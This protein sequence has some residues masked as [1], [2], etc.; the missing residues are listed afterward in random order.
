MD[1]AAVSD[2]S[3]LGDT[4]WA[5]VALLFGGIALPDGVGVAGYELGTA[6]IVVA[7]VVLLL[8]LATSCSRCL[9][10]LGK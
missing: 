6:A 8:P 3:N 4:Y 1:E 9:A 5:G 7:A 2:E 10:S